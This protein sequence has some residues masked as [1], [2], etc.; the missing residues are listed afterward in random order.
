MLNKIREYLKKRGWEFDVSELQISS[1]F[2]IELD[3]RELLFPLYFMSI[4][5]ISQEKYVRL[6]VVP[7]AEQT[8]SGYPDP[9]YARLAHINHDLTQAK[10]A[11][12]ADGDIELLLDIP[13]ASIND[14]ELDDAMILLAEIAGAYHQ[15][16]SDLILEHK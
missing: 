14:T 9:L 2:T 15:E 3:D 8:T 16:F 1:G 12:D 7:F 11:L 10:F 4:Q 5:Q 13:A 6:A